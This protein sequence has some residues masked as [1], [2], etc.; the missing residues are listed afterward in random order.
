GK[1]EGARRRE[2]GPPGE[3]AG[4]ELQAMLD[5]ELNRLPGKYRAPFVLCCLAGKSKAEAAAELEWK[6]GTVSSRLARAREL[7]QTR[8]ARR[9]VALSAVLSGLAISE[10]GPATAVPAAL[11][12]TVLEAVPRFLSGEVVATAPAALARSVL[13]GMGLVRVAIAGAILA[14]LGLAGTA[15]AVALRPRPVDPE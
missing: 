14:A 12:T 1:A 9:G 4:R 8:L 5:E 7:L 6:E 11:V 15:T 2:D 13:R 10:S 3:M